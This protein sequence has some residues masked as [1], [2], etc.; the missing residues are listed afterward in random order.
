MNT[1][2][3]LNPAFIW[4]FTVYVTSRARGYAVRGTQDAKAMLAL[5]G[6]DL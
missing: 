1:K 3:L 6:I 5:E 4:G 2:N